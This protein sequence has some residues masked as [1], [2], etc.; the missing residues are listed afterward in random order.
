M[1]GIQPNDHR[2][3][4]EYAL[5]LARKSPPRPTN[6]RVGAVVVDP[7]TNEVLAGGY[8]LELEGNTHA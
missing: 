2:A 1:S 5:S 6:Y 7:A 8:T 3:Y 4:M